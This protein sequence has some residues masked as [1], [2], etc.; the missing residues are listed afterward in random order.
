MNAMQYEIS[1]PA[2]YDMGIIRD[3]VA[4]RGATFD[5]YP[6]L[7]LKAFLNF[8]GATVGLIVGAAT[9][10][11]LLVNDLVRRH[12]P[13]I[14]EI[15]TF[16]IFAGLVAWS[17][18]FPSPLSVLSIRLRVDIGLLL[19]ILISMAIAKPFSSICA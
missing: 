19:I 16:L 14:L 1:L 11:A 10:G 2:D 18:L 7:G 5:D 3:R 4:T 13:K 12:Q 6:G 15:G 8:W 9:S 17:S